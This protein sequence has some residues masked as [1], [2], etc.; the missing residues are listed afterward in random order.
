MPNRGSKAPCSSSRTTP[1]TPSRAPPQPSLP[2]NRSSC[3][4]TEFAKFLPA[5]VVV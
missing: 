3:F 2:G 5:G 4:R 1:P